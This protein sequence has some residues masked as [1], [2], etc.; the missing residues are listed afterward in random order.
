MKLIQPLSATDYASWEP[1]RQRVFGADDWDTGKPPPHPGWRFLPMLN[2]LTSGPSPRHPHHDDGRETVR[3]EA[4]LLETLRSLGRERLYLRYGG[5]AWILPVTEEAIDEARKELPIFVV[6]YFLCDLSADWGVQC[7]PDTTISVV[8]GS[9]AFI[10]AYLHQAGGELALRKRFTQFDF[11]IKW[12]DEDGHPWPTSYRERLYRAFGWQVPPYP[13]KGCWA[14]RR[15]DADEATNRWHPVL[16]RLLPGDDTEPHLPTEWRAL[17]MRGHMFSEE[18]A[19]GTMAAV[20]RLEEYNALL[21]VLTSADRWELCVALL[22]GKTDAL[23]VVPP[24]VSAF[25]VEETEGKFVAAFG[26]EGDWLLLSYPEDVS[27]LFGEP[28]L[29][30]RVVAY[31]G[32]WD[33]C[34]SRFDDWASAG[35]IAPDILKKVRQHAGW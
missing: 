17:P 32:G 20:P 3:E 13:N 2:H 29:I 25:G 31:A 15:P 7:N 12:P 18:W 33:A 24:T 21:F 11:G 14:E 1:A 35:P 27:V 26:P 8:G 16:R 34:R 28:D 4:L 6:E 23:W 10:D 5:E 30:Q 19:F 22:E 9:Q